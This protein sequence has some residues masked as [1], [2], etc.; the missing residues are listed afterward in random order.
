MNVYGRNAD[1]VLR[2]LRHAGA[3][4][5][6]CQSLH[7]KSGSGLINNLKASKNTITDLNLEK[8]GES[9]LPP[10]RR[11]HLRHRTGTLD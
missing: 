6:M 10:G 9:T 3:W 7:N 8:E 1:N 11:I 5:P 2:V 4:R